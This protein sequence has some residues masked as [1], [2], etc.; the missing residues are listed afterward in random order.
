MKY[1]Q[2]FVM[3]VKK[4][5]IDVYRRTARK[6]A[7]IWKEHGA[8]EVVET[9]AENVKK[10]KLTSYPQAVDLKRNET[11]VVSWV[12]FK[13][14]KHCERVSAKVM[15]DPR[16]LKLMNPEDLPADGHRTFWGGFDVMIRL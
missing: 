15:E 13:T 11:V 2:S 1:V 9:V 10:G 16:V 6:F 3:P 5:K 14:K 4:N 8:L 7:K 12:T